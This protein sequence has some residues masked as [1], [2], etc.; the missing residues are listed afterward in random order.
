MSEL[1]KMDLADGVAVWVEVPEK[2]MPPVREIG[3][4][5]RVEEG[6]REALDVVASFG[7]EATARLARLALAEVAGPDEVKI[8]FGVAVG[9][10]AGVVLTSG[11]VE[12]NLK[13]SLTWKRAA[14]KERAPA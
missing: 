3:A 2:L 7:Q 1:V 6:L 13:V 11:S 12:G 5:E 14:G 4:R 9:A 8:E 10:A